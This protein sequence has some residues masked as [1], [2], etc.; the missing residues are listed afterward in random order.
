MNMKKKC[1]IGGFISTLF[2]SITGLS[3]GL[4]YYFNIPYYNELTIKGVNEIDINEIIYLKVNNKN[5]T[6]DIINPINNENYLLTRFFIFENNIPTLSQTILNSNFTK[7]S[8]WDIIDIDKNTNN[9]I[10][11]ELNNLNIEINIDGTISNIQIQ[12]RKPVKYDNYDII[13]YSFDKELEDRI[14]KNLIN[15]ENPNITDIQNDNNTSSPFLPPSNIDPKCLYNLI[16]TAMFSGKNLVKT[17]FCNG[18]SVVAIGGT[19]FKS[20]GDIWANVVGALDDNFKTGFERLKNFDFKVYDICAGYS[21]GGGIAKYMATQNYCKNVFTIGAPYTLKYNNKIPII[22]YSNTVDD[23]EGCC[24]FNWLGECKQRG[25][26]LVDPVTLI[27]TGSHRNIKYIGNRKNNNCKGNFA[28]TAWKN[29]FNL[30]LL[31][32]YSDNLPNQIKN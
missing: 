9:N 19:N 27:L 20:V 15:I 25:M 17:G 1:I 21:L 11:I 6:Y 5:V 7:L 4:Y 32:T 3:I 22:Q 10:N 28:Y 26:Y 13:D 23:D 14:F 12:N 24:K 29:K 8:N 30:H 2:A 31:G 16:T 18:Y